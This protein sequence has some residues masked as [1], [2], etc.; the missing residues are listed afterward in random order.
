MNIL[1]FGGTSEGRALTD[2]LLQTGHTVTLSVATDY[3]AALI[4]AAPGLTVRTG[5][6]DRTAMDALLASAPFGC[7][8]DA[9]HPYAVAVTQTLQS[10]AQ[11]AGLPY[12]RLLRDGPGEGDWPTVPDLAQAAALA[13]TLTGNLLLTTGAKELAPFA[14]PGLIERTFPRVLP[15]RDSLDRCLT[16]G[17]PPAHIL[18]MQGPFSQALNAALIRQHDIRLLVTKA[19]GSPGGFREKAA[20][21]RETGC[22]LIVVARPDQTP[23]YTLEELKGIVG[24]AGTP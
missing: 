23:G 20:A 1:L 21:A 9:T 10:A 15:S 7:G 14:V 11:A 13:Q 24:S 17:F 8:I 12:H 2:W 5:C 19:S 22:T 18:C 6:L 4:P 3:G 16:L